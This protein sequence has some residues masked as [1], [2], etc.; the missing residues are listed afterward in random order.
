MQTALPRSRVCKDEES[1]ADGSSPVT[2]SVKTRRLRRPPREGGDPAIGLSLIRVRPLFGS[3]VQDLA[4]K[5]QRQYRK[6]SDVTI[7]IFLNRDEKLRTKVK[8][9]PTEVAG[10]WFFGYCSPDHRWLFLKG[11]DKQG[12]RQCR[13]R[14]HIDVE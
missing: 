9:D 10:I 2:A 11:M 5:V 13:V 3:P 8:F 7:A 4:S 14:F 1:Y 12:Q 6:P